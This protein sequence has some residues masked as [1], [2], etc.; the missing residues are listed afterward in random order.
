MEEGLWKGEGFGLHILA[1]GFA[2][3]FPRWIGIGRAGGRGPFEFLGKILVGHGG[4]CGRLAALL[5]LFGAIDHGDGVWFAGDAH[6]GCCRGWRL[7]LI[8]ICSSI[9]SIWAGC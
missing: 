5:G 2:F 4:G 6:L 7:L 1:D 3:T 9:A 8:R